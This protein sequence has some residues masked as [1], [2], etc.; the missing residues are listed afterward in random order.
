ML[1]L[2]DGA[3]PAERHCAT[4]DTAIGPCGIAWRGEAV[5]HVLLP[6]IDRDATLAELRWQSGGE[7]APPPWPVFISH[8]VAGIQALLRG[9]PADLRDVPLDWAGIGQFERQV[10]EAAQQVMPGHHCTYE[11]LAQAMGSPGS[12]RA[13]DVALARN[14]C[15]LI[16]PCHRVVAGLDKL[17]SFAG[18]GGVGTKKKL[19]QI[20]AAIFKGRGKVT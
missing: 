10:Y 15:P 3:L 1:T 8:A 11:E 7:V 5:T 18:A 12:A 17:G 19:L 13:V 14:P 2:G 9:E 20:E 16:V 4:F 6:L